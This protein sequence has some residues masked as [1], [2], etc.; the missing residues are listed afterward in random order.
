MPGGEVQPGDDRRDAKTA[1][2]FLSHEASDEVF[3]LQEVVENPADTKQPYD[4]LGFMRKEQNKY[5]KLK[6]CDPQKL[7]TIPTSDPVQL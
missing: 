7:F 4:F 1:S 5:A 2:S 6:F 3:C